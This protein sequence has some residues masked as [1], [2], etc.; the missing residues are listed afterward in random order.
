MQKK[1]QLRGRTNRS[2][3]ISVLRIYELRIHEIHEIALKAFLE[4][5]L[6]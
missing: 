2:A 6:K 5:K 3:R 4:F 1:Y